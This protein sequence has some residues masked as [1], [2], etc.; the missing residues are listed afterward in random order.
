[1]TFSHISEQFSL[2]LECRY[3]SE[4]NE[5]TKTVRYVEKDQQ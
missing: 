4:G 2:F 3:D 1:M 5:E